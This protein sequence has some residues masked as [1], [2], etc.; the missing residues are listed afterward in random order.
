M[1]V[2]RRAQPTDPRRQ[3]AIVC[4]KQRHRIAGLSFFFFFAWER[5]RKRRRHVLLHSSSEDAI[6]AQK[7]AR[8]E[9]HSLAYSGV[10]SSA[11]DYAVACGTKCLCYALTMH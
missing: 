5:Q 6:E 8:S 3:N 1:G 4:R 7:P 2:S 10:A 9:G 11:F